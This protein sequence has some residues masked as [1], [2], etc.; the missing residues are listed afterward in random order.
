[1]PAASRWLVGSSSSR[2]DG[3]A[4]S[5]RASITGP[6][7]RRTGCPA[8]DRDRS[9]RRRAG[10]GP[11]AYQAHPVPAGQRERQ[12]PEQGSPSWDTARLT[13]FNQAGTSATSVGQ[14]TGNVAVTTW[15]P[16]CRAA[17]RP[18]TELPEQRRHLGR[19]DLAEVPI[20]PADRAEV[21]GYQR[22]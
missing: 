20:E 21:R 15:A 14:L 19:A 4:S 16:C 1:M 2:T 8:V 22:A 5:T 12:A 7:R 13:A 17:P 10:S 11:R 6:A 3:S 9:R 18:A